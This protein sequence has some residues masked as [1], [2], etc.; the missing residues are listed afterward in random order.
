MDDPNGESL[1][2]VRI[3]IIYNRDVYLWFGP[4]T[5]ITIEDIFVT[6]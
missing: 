5:N 4:L 1:R 6:F 2:T 3:G